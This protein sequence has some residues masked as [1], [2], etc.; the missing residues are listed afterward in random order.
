M[1]S[2]TTPGSPASDATASLDDLAP[3]R[4]GVIAAIDAGGAVGRRLGDLGFVPGTAVAVVRRAPLGDPTLYALRGTE[5]A[6]RREEARRV[7]VY[8][9]ANGAEPLR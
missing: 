2:P 5:I 6:L 4:H 3:G 9:V 8:L 7:R 1:T